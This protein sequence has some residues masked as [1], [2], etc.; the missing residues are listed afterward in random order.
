VVGGNNCLVEINS[1]AMILEN[2]Y[3]RQLHKNHHLP[4]PNHEQQMSKS[5]RVSYYL[6]QKNIIPKQENKHQENIT[7]K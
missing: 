6:F 4:T 7:K 5:I 3:Q 1:Q 2:G